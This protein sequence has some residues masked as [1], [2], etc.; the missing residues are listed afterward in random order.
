MSI[1]QQLNNVIRKQIGTYITGVS[2]S[3]N[4]NFT[5]LHMCND[6]DN[7]LKSTY[8]LSFR[9]QSIQCI[10]SIYFTCRDKLELFKPIPLF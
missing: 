1:I 2:H 10:L 6:N 3:M 4:Q 9:I 5:Y 7:K 8:M